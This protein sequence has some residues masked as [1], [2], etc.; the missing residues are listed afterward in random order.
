[1]GFP[2][3]RLTPVAIET[4]EEFVITVEELDFSFSREKT[5]LQ[6]L[7]LKIPRGKITAIMGPSG[8]GKTTLLRIFAGLNKPTGGSFSRTT[9]KLVFVY[10]QNGL[11]PWYTAYDNVVLPMRI[12]NEKNIAFE[13][14][15]INAL[16]KVGLQPEDTKKYPHELS[17]GMRKR[18]EL[19]RVL[20]T[21]AELWLLDEPF[22]SLD[23]FTRMDMVALL[24]EH[25]RSQKATVILVTHG[26][27]DVLAIADQV[28]VIGTSGNIHQVIDITSDH[29]RDI[30]S[31]EFQPLRKQLVHALSST[32]EK[33]P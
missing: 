6:G 4:A 33:T 30:A 23:P 20:V 32:G 5:L 25:Q 21:N 18:V 10:Q 7:S 24:G 12:S 26:F 8:C 2:D 11:L 19:A 28:C 13:E 14:V 16:C 27:D 3:K 17:G 31:P 1:M 15:G 29:P 9:K 22:E